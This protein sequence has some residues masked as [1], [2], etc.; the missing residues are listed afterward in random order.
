LART[1]HWALAILTLVG[2]DDTLFNGNEAASG[3]FL[4]DV[5]H[6][7]DHNCLEC[8][9]GLTAE[10]GLDLSTDFCGAVLTGGIVVPGQPDASLLY[11]RMRSPSDPMPPSGRLPSADLELVRQWIE[12]GAECE[13]VDWTGE[14]DTGASSDPGKQL[15]DQS[16]AGCHGADGGGSNGP[17]MT[18]VVPGLTAQQVADIARGGSGG[19]PPVLPDPDEALLVGEYCVAEWGG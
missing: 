5:L 14:T 18:A 3:V 11:L 16:C 2:C 6:I 1:V 12:D 7:I 15:Y 19:M 13:G 10:A 8:H 17:A 9:A 4:E